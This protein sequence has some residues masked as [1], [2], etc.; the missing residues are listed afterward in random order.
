MDQNWHSEQE[1]ETLAEENGELIRAQK[2]NG[3]IIFMSSV[4][5]TIFIVVYVTGIHDGFSL[6]EIFTGPVLLFFRFFGLLSAILC[7]L[8]IL[9]RT[10]FGDAVAVATEDGLFYRKGMLSWAEIQSVTLHPEIDSHHQTN[11]THAIV[12]VRPFAERERE[13]RIDRFP[14]YGLR[15]IRKHRPGIKIK[16]KGWLF[17]AML[18]LLMPVGISIFLIFLLWVR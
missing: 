16:W 13:V 8:S 15:I 17:Y 5:V 7:L 1:L 9:N 12:L 3:Y 6:Q 4:L 14:A 10:Y 11:G 18:E 2:F